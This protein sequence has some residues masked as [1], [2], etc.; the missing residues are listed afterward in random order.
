MRQDSKEDGR[1]V[2]YS[3]E[4]A[5]RILAVNPEVLKRAALLGQIHVVELSR[6]RLIPRSE[7]ERLAGGAIGGEK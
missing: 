5:G 3:F 6:R 2:L 1:K 7:I 4:S